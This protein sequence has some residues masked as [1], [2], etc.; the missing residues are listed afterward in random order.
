MIWVFGGNLSF[1]GLKRLLDL[2]GLLGLLGFRG[3]SSLL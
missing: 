1:Y 3:L 2:V